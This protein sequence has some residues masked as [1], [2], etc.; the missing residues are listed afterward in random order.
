MVVYTEMP[1]HYWI[2]ALG[3]RGSVGVFLWQTHLLHMQ[4]AG[5]HIRHATKTNPQSLARACSV[6][7]FACDAQTPN[8]QAATQ[9]D[10]QA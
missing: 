5:I 6:A 3:Q 2:R 7:A 10:S 8:T 9:A 1:P 4:E